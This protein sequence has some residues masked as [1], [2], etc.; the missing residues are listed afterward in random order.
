[1]S[2]LQVA[3]LPRPNMRDEAFVMLLVKRLGEGSMWRGLDDEV[4]KIIVR[5]ILDFV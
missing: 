5:L 3:W 4:N 1:V 2:D